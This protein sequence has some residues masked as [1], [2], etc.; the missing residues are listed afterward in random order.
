MSDVFSKSKRSQVM[1]QIRGRANESTEIALALILRRHGIVGWRRHRVLSLGSHCT[2]GGKGVAPRRSTH[3]RPDFVFSRQRVVVFV[4]G[5]FWHSCP[6]HGVRPKSNRVF[7]SQK[8]SA[9]R[10]RDE[11]VRRILKRRGWRIL[12]LWEHDLEDAERVS[13]SLLRLLGVPAHQHNDKEVIRE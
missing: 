4:D 11:R 8:L 6:L 2:K 1:S 13:R 12:R 7:W 10:L 3:V 5:C 9:N